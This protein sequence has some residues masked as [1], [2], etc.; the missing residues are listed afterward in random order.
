MRKILFPIFCV[1]IAAASASAQVNVSKSANRKLSIDFSGM[2][3]GNDSASQMF[4]RT[5]ENDLKRSGWF[6]PMHSSQ[7]ELRLVGT[8]NPSGQ[9]L[10]V[11]AQVYRRGDSSRVFSRSYQI[12]TGKARTLSHRVADD[13]VEAITG[14]KGIASGRIA[15]VGNR[16]GVKELYLCDAD[17]GNLVQATHDRGI[18]V[19]PS[20]APDNNTLVYTSYLRNFPDVYSIDLK[21]GRRKKM[22]GYAG[23]NTGA[24]VSP[25]GQSMALILSKDG[26]PELYIQNLRSGQLQ[27]MTQ[28]RKA[29]EASPNWSPDGKNLV[30]VSD[31]SG[32]PQL[33]I[34]S[35]AGGRPRRLT[36][37]GSQNVDP[38]W[39]TNGLIT[40]SSRSGGRYV[41]AII[42]P[43][44][45]ETSYLK[46]DGA[47]YEGP[48]WAPD[49]RHLIASRSVNYQSSL[50]LLDTVNDAPVAL[51]HGGGSWYSP[52]WSL[53]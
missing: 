19:G 31:Q 48:S 18:V 47:D 27:R 2:R 38:D 40:C 17:G 36:S 10:K 42:Q 14:H 29:T 26:N 52:A 32:S 7:G 5:L 30:F 4:N 43:S 28:T 16:N 46:T 45:G 6:E 33:Y 20:W 35:R 50:Y 37:R 12:E 25:D 53:R 8:A 23:L 39:G 1:L 44:T 9:T 41:I 15:L 51:L 34:I 13:I 49:G 24:S 21:R 11:I 22:S 3:A